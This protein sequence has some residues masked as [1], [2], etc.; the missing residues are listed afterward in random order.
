MSA[1]GPS[2]DALPQV[3]VEAGI[4]GVDQG[5]TLTRGGHTGVAVLTKLIEQGPEFEIY[6]FAPVG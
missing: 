4:F 5:V 2:P 1:A 6:D 3:I